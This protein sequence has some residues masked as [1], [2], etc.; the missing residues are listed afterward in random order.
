MLLIGLLR[1]PSP[2]WCVL[3]AIGDGMMKLLD[4][5]VDFRQVLS[6]LETAPRPLH[7]SFAR[8]SLG[9][10]ATSIISQSESSHY[11]I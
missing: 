11:F 3:V 10:I 9:A 4:N 1:A 5:D 7:L 2:G 6:I 8:G